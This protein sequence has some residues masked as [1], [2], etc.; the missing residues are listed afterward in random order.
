[1]NIFS[2]RI[3]GGPVQEVSIKSGLYY[4]A[5]ATALATLDYPDFDQDDFIE[6]WV[7]NLLPDYGPYFYSFDSHTISCQYQSFMDLKAKR[8]FSRTVTEASIQKT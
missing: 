8:P 7:E 5:V 1:M 2:V 4:L 3:N 6:I